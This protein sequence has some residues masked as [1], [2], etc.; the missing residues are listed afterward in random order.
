M[1]QC[2]FVRSGPTQHGQYVL[3]SKK[4]VERELASLDH[5]AERLMAF[6]AEGND[7]AH[8]FNRTTRFE[9]LTTVRREAQ[10]VRVPAA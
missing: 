2:S 3:F 4:S 7:Q 9:V 6:V 5:L 1:K 10:A 8:L